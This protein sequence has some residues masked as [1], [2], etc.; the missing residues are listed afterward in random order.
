MADAANP[1]RTRSRRFELGENRQFVKAPNPFLSRE[2]FR[3]AV[4][5]NYTLAAWSP[6]HVL[7]SVSPVIRGWTVTARFQ[8]RRAGSG[9]E[10][11]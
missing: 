9:Y 1:A 4:G 8:R 7:G 6:E 5:K 10:P 2:N 3:K 11:A